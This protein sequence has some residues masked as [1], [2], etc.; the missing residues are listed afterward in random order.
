MITL[1]DTLITHLTRLR[2]QIIQNQERNQFIRENYK[3][4]ENA[5]EFW[6]KYH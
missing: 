2:A 1:I 5:G 3:D 6:D 4:I